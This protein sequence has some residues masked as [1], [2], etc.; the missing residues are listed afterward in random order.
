M[1]HRV[2]AREEIIDLAHID[3]LHQKVF[4]SFPMGSKDVFDLLVAFL[5]LELCQEGKEA[6][7]PTFLTCKSLLSLFERGLGE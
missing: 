1:R 7:S 3:F 5:F 2:T 6:S 4:L